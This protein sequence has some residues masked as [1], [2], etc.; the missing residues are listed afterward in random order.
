[1]TSW[2]RAGCPGRVENE[3]LSLASPP[4]R[5]REDPPRAAYG[6]RNGGCSMIW[7]KRIRYLL[8]IFVLLLV[9]S[10]D[11]GKGPM[12]VDGVENISKDAVNVPVGECNYGV[13]YIGPLETE[14]PE[15]V[16]KSEKV[17]LI[18][19]SLSEHS[20][21]RLLSDGAVLVSD[22]YTIKIMMM[23]TKYG[24]QGE[25]GSFWIISLFGETS[26][27]CIRCCYKDPSCC[28]PCP[29]CCSEE[30]HSPKK[31]YSLLE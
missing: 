30:D 1:L 3:K 16:V 29:A 6:S 9:S 15:R 13:L 31:A 14:E 28:T 7:I 8:V 20:R 24:I 25:E 12:G 18:L 5:G 21:E 26:W 22:P 10:C 11:S 4:G 19:S 23:L 27:S 17:S 2:R